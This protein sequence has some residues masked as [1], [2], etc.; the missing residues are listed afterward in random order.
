MVKKLSSQN[1]FK[2]YPEAKS[3][4]HIETPEQVSSSND[5]VRRYTGLFP[6]KKILLATKRQSHGRGRRGKQFYSEL[7]EALYF[8]LAWPQSIEDSNNKLYTHLGA[9]SVC[10]SIEEYFH[11][12]PRIKWVN[13]VF[14]D[15]RKIAG[16]LCESYYDSSVGKQYF[17]LGIGINIAGTFA[18][19]SKETQAIAGTI[20]ADNSSKEYDP[21]SFLALILKNI[22]YLEKIM[23]TEDFIQLYRE[24]MLGIGQVLEI[25]NADKILQATI[26][27]INSKGHLHLKINGDTDMYY[28]NAELSFGS[29]QFLNLITI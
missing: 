9:L 22:K 26:L 1:I 25:K 17:I 28:D 11:E 15:N 21:N 24:R 18:N 10:L 16:I 3:W 13:D 6:D 23:E 12:N 4:L 19:A 20:L 29:E 5:E 27:G 2:V 14:L 7:E 8:S